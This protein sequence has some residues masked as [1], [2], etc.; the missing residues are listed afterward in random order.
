MCL[1]A[2]AILPRAAGDST[3]LP[4]M[5]AAMEIR[6]KDV[7]F[8][9]ILSPK[10]AIKTRMAAIKTRAQLAVEPK[11]K[12]RGAMQ[13]RRCSWFLSAGDLHNDLE[14]E[15]SNST[16]G[17]SFGSDSHLDDALAHSL[18]KGD[19]GVKSPRGA[20]KGACWNPP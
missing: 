3:I 17:S 5:D 16:D 7:H 2:A 4:P 8:Q 13:C 20:R 14:T 11:N 18:R 1:W 10:A 6:W 12:F 15:D 9:E 19:S